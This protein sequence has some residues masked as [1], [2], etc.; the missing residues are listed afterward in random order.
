MH[1][2]VRRWNCDPLWL[3]WQNK[4][5]VRSINI[6][7][8]DFEMEIYQSQGVVL[9]SWCDCMSVLY[10]NETLLCHTVWRLEFMWEQMIYEDEK[11]CV[12]ANEWPTK[13]LISCNEEWVT[14][15]LVR[16]TE[17]QNITPD[18]RLYWKPYG[19][20]KGPKI[21]TCLEISPKVWRTCHTRC[22]MLQKTGYNKTSKKILD[23]VL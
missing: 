12:N 21:L 5:N 7:A 18:Q 14:G 13:T 8:V 6:K 2:K 4:F 16:V 9:H 1:R 22:C 19:F 10:T 20:E 11:E 3:V 17:G 15:G 23:C